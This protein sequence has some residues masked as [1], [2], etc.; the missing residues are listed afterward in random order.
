LR[1]TPAVTN[2]DGKPP[3][4]SAWILAAAAGVAVAVAATIPK[5]INTRRPTVCTRTVF[6]LHP[7]IVT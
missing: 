4:G 6:T 7:L 3:C 2:S 1:L 5:S